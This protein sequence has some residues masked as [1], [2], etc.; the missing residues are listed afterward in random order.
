MHIKRY[1]IIT[2]VYLRFI[3]KHSIVKLCLM[4]EAVVVDRYL[5]IISIFYF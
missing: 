1:S 5:L 2:K 4:N 3:Q